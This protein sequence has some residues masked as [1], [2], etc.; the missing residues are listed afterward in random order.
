[1]I[2]RKLR[3]DK[4]DFGDGENKDEIEIFEWCGKWVVDGEDNVFGMGVNDDTANWKNGNLGM[5]N[6]EFDGF[7]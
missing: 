2:F 1:M 6:T 3:I 7:G 5:R 4:R